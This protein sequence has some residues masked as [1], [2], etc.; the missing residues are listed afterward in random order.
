MN[1][2]LCRRGETHEGE[3]DCGGGTEDVDLH[4]CSSMCSHHNCTC[5]REKFYLLALIIIGEILKVLLMDKS[6]NNCEDIIMC[7]LQPTPLVRKMHGGN[8]FATQTYLVCCL[9]V[10]NGQLFDFPVRG[11][12]D[13]LVSF[14]LICWLTL[15][16]ISSRCAQGK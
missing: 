8:S 1:H 11:F 6:G 12:L 14:L 3:L 15:I 2:F 5:H 13:I 4:L 9:W 10:E 16:R 7:L